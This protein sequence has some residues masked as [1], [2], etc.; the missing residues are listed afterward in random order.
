M[1]R[2]KVYAISMVRNGKSVRAIIAAKSQKEAAKIA[3]WSLY[4]FGRY[5]AETGNEEEIKWAKANPGI[6]LIHPQW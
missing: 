6:L 1:N 2:L 5:C 3:G 4:A